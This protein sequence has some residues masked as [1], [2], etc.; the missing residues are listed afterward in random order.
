MLCALIHLIYSYIT[1]T[2]AISKIVEK[3]P[4]NLKSF[5]FPP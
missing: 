2:G 3:Y 1:D 4:F 5:Q